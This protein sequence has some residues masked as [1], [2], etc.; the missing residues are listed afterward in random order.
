MTFDAE[1]LDIHL[2]PSVWYRLILV[3]VHSLAIVALFNARLDP[4]LL[5]ALVFVV[6]TAM[7]YSF[8]RFG[9]LRSAQSVVHITWDQEAWQLVLRSGR[10]IPVQLESST[11]LGWLVVLNFRDANK[12]DYPVSLFPDSTSP[13]EFRRLKVLLNHP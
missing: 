5:G 10:V 11:V 3:T 2:V 1:H 9:M 7:A 12:E 6:V 8:M 4:W 13:D